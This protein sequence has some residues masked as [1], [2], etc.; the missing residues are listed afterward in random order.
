[1]PL[2]VNISSTDLVLTYLAINS[3]GSQFVTSTNEGILFIYGLND[4][5]RYYL[6][7]TIKGINK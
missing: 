4:K 1:M 7:K 5:N 2:N 6:L 3:D